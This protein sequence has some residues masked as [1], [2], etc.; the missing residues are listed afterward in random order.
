MGVTKKLLKEG[1]QKT[2]PVEGDRVKIE[3]TGWIHDPARLDCKGKQFDTSVG[4]GDFET[5]IGMGKLI[6][7]SPAPSSADEKASGGSPE[8]LYYYMQAC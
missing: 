3:Y 5:E 7:G 1:D 6:K 2:K 4:R 8:S